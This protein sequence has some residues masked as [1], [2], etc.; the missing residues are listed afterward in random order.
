MPN[1]SEAAGNS[2]QAPGLTEN[3]NLICDMV[4]L[5]IVDFYTPIFCPMDADAANRQQCG[6]RCHIGQGP[7]ISGQSP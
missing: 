7:D 3:R 2:A 4:H 1:G 6:K 5:L